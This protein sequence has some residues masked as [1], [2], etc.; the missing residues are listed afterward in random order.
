MSPRLYFSFYSG[1]PNGNCPGKLL[2]GYCIARHILC[3]CPLPLCPFD[4]GRIRYCGS[5]RSLIPAI[6]GLYPSQHLNK[7]PLRNY[8]HRSKPYLLSPTFPRPGRHTSSILRLPG[9]LHSLKYS[10]LHRLINL[11][12]RS[13]Y[14]PIYY[15]RGICC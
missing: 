12:R 3:S 14:I 13:N 9:R 6:L 8:V 15:L 4:G 2:T 7:N 5:L 10:L 1:G 11:T